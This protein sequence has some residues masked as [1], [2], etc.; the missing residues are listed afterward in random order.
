MKYEDLTREEQIRY[1]GYLRDERAFIENLLNQRFNFLLIVFGLVIATF[2]NVHSEDQLALNLGFGF[3][4][5]TFFALVIGRAQ[6]RLDV[7]L[8]MLYK[9]DDDPIREIQKQASSGAWYNIYRL[10][11]KRFIGYY[12]PFSLWCILL[13]SLLYHKCLFHFIKQSV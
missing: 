3:V 8:K 12:I 10:S 7:N 9:L 13:V 11:V 6:R 4:L 2:P 5:V 1:H